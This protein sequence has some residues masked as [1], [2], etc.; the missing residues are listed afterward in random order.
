MVIIIY[1]LSIYIPYNCEDLCSFKLA[2]NCL[3]TLCHVQLVN[4][5]TPGPFACQTRTLQVVVF[6]RYSVLECNTT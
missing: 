6:P 2:R 5:H 4:S 1:V 3:L